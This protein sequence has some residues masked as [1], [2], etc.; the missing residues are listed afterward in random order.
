MLTLFLFFAVVAFV[1]SVTIIIARILIT[2]FTLMYY[3]VYDCY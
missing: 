2:V 1:L 3:V